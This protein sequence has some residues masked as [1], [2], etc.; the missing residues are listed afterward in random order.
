MNN[1]FATRQQAMT[2]VHD[3]ADRLAGALTPTQKS[4]AVGVL[5]GMRGPGVVRGPRG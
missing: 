2:A 3:A 5:P 4:Q 1:M